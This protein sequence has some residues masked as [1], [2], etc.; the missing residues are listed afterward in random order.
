[1]DKIQQFLSEHRLKPY[2]NATLLNRKDAVVFLG[3]LRENN[4]RLLGFDGFHLLKNVSPRAI[5]IDQD[6]SA[7]Y[8]DDSFE[9]SYQKAKDFFEQH[10]EGD[11]AYEFVYDSKQKKQV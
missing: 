3:L 5:Q 11:I 8:S 10:K 1:M 9:I 6:Y 4:L 7:D 2:D